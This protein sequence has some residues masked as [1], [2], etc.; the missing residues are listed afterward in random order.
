[1]RCVSCS[2]LL[3]G[4]MLVACGGKTFEDVGGHGDAAVD[5]FTPSDNGLPDAPDLRACNGT[6]ECSLVPTTC[7]GTCSQPTTENM[8]AVTKGRETEW[9][10]SV[11][12][13]EPVG[14]PACAPVIPDG[15][16]QARCVAKRCTAID[17]R[18]EPVSACASDADC[19]LR[20]KDCCEGCD[21][22]LFDL[23]AL[24]SSKVNDYRNEV[25]V[26]DE[27]CPRCSA[28]YPPEAKAV[29]DLATKHCRVKSP[30]SP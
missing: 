19:Q 12:G 28:A 16:I 30:I 25:C 23:V 18:K 6:N 9:S 20:Y 7:C 13:P 11:C 24:N 4:F 21:V 3:L 26:G 10:K 15:S 5:T 2:S 27:A 14:C 8:T 1:M 17:V 29:C 22:N